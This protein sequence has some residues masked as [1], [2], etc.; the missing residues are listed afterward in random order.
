[1]GD[2]DCR[3]A[4]WDIFHKTGVFLVLQRGYA[5]VEDRD[6]FH[7]LLT[8]HEPLEYRKTIISGAD[9]IFISTR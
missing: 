9:S 5:C 6:F 3:E 1:M 4:Q 8:P 7:Y 2:P